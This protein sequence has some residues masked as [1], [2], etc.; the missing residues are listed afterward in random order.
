MQTASGPAPRLAKPIVMV[1]L[2][3][4]ANRSPSS[5]SLKTRLLKPLNRLQPCAGAKTT[6]P[7]LLRRGA[8]SPSVPCRLH[9]SG[10][11]LPRGGGVVEG[12]G[13]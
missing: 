9:I 8:L 11:A 7:G 4:K 12:E 10:K 6:G 2:S 13:L 5:L 1:F 3:H